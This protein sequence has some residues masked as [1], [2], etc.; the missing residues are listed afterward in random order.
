VVSG[1][2]DDEVPVFNFGDVETAESWQGFVLT[3]SGG[4]FGREHPSFSSWFRFA[5]SEELW[6]NGSSL[7]VGK[8]AVGVSVGADGPV[9]VVLSD[10]FDMMMEMMM[11]IKRED[12][13]TVDSQCARFTSLGYLIY[14]F[15]GSVRVV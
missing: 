8:D 13:V 7:Y 14:R 15:F 12:V 3:F 9:A 2:G 11:M 1:E 5:W 4:A 6:E 10:S